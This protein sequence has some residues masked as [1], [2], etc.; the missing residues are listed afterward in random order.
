MGSAPHIHIFSNQIVY[1]DLGLNEVQEVSFVRRVI[2]LLL[3]ATV[4]LMSFGCGGGGTLSLSEYQERISELHEDVLADLG[5]VTRSLDSIPYDDYWGLLELE[6]V[7][8]LSYESFVSAGKEASGITPPPEAE[9]LHQDLV[10]YYLLGE[11]NMD[12][13]I[14]GIRFFQSVLPML[15]DMDNLAL[16]QLQED[17]GPTQIEAA[18]TEDRK[19]MQ[20][21]IKDLSGMKPPATLWDYQDDLESLFRALEDIIGRLDQSV[22]SGDNAAL[23][24]YQ[25]EYEAVLERVH[26]FWEGAMDYLG[27]MQQRMDFLI[28]RGEALSARIDE[29]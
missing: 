15:V 22:A 8:E 14:N 29:L 21:Y 17:A 23:P 3:T 12:S 4:L 27:L 10:G 25:Q 18:S 6:D 24:T 20:I 19:T 2:P 11:I 7:F 26:E 16:P 5:D 1:N 13:I 28:M 9:S